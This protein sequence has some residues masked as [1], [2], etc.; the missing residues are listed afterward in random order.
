MKIQE[1]RQLEA[2][3][4]ELQTV[5]EFSVVANVTTWPDKVEKLS[6]LNVNASGE[7]TSLLAKWINDNQSTIIEAIKVEGTKAL[8]DVRAEAVKEAEV[9]LEVEKASIKSV[10]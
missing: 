7:F 6:Q 8:E 4:S 10:I 2:S 9:F 5:T 3:L 1:F